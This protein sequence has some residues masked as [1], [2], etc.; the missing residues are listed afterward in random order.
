MVAMFALGLGIADAAQAQKLE[1]VLAHTYRN[2]PQIQ[3]Q[4][5]LLRATDESIAQARAGWR[6]TVSVNSSVGVGNIDR[7]GTRGDPR[8]FTPRSSSLDVAQPILRG[9]RTEAAIRRSRAQI[10]AERARL[11]VVEQQVFQEAITAYLNLVR[12][13]ATLALRVNNVQV[14]GRQLEAT[15]DQFRVGV[16]TRTDVAQSESRLA[17][18][19][20]DRSAAEGLLTTTRATFQRV[21]G[22]AP[23][24]VT[25]PPPPSDLPS[26][27]IE[28]IAAA[29]EANP[30]VIA[31]RFDEQVSLA[32]VEEVKGELL[33]TLSLNGQMAYRAN[34]TPGQLSQTSAQATLNLSVPLYEAGSVYSRVRQARQTTSQRAA[35]LENTRRVVTEQ[36]TQAFESMQSAGARVVALEAQVAASE[37]ALEGVRQEA[38]VG[39]RTVLDV[40]NAE[41]ERLN[42]QVALVQSQRDFLVASYQLRAALGRLTAQGMALPIELYDFEANFNAVQGRWWGIDPADEN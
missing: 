40:L 38:S 14:L 28:A 29:A 37:I 25:A 5:A 6:P 32:Q 1:E 31:A 4:R 19:R 26:G 30:S 15:R 41:Q 22:L 11:F 42:A 21:V 33:P 23:E 18:A 35:Q 7:Q 9:G 20:A 24:R 39:S 12:D 16:V 3:A 17:G 2:N 27:L 10:Q 13:E 34:Q 8:G 36:A